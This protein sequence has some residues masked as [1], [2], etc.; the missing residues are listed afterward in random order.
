MQRMPILPLVTKDPKGVTLV[1]GHPIV[2]MAGVI[3]IFNA[4]CY[5]AVQPQEQPRTPSMPVKTASQAH[6]P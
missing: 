3:V 4:L 5:F 2:W 1:R 6:T